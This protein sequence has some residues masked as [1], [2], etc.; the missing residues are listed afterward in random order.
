LRLVELAFLDLA[1]PL[2]RGF[3]F[4]IYG[5]DLLFRLGVVGVAA[6]SIMID[7]AR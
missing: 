3:L 6:A 4:C 7:L 2:R 1:T 5:G